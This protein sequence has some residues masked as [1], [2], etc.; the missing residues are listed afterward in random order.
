MRTR[1]MR[2][3]TLRAREGVQRVARGPFGR[4]GVGGLSAGRCSYCGALAAASASTC[5]VCGRS[6]QQVPVP[7]PPIEPAPAVEAP[8][9]VASPAPHP[10]IEATP[11]SPP[12]IEA[13]P[14]LET[15]LP[16]PAPPRLPPAVPPDTSLR[17]RYARAQTSAR[18]DLI[19]IVSVVTLVG[20]AFAGLRLMADTGSSSADELEL[21][22]TRTVGTPRRPSSASPTSTAVGKAGPTG[23]GEPRFMAVNPVPSPSLLRG[24]GI[25]RASEPECPGTGQRVCIV[26]MGSAPAVDVEGLATYIRATYPAPV[27]VLPSISMGGIEEYDGRIVDQGRQQLRG[28]QTLQLLRQRYPRSYEDPL[29]TILVVTPYDMYR[30]FTEAPYLYSVRAPKPGRIAVVSNAR[31]DDGAWGD[32]PNSELLLARTRKLVAREVGA[33]HFGLPDSTDPTSLMHPTLG[34]RTAVDRAADRLDLGE[35]PPKP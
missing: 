30:E 34:T 20:L 33:L 23:P 19:R 8:V 14:V 22:P 27:A 32:P 29:V 31:M 35:A 12:P 15:P 3:D 13:A 18:F 9:P 7:A 16:P 28:Q 17:V 6:L 5:R 2:V 4:G 1:S 10:L 26:A 24:K 11:A 21:F 25:A